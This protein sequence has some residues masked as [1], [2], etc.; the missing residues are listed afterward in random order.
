M[1]GTVGFTA[2]L[3]FRGVALFLPFIGKKA[4]FGGARLPLS[5]G[6]A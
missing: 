4:I 6:L 3:Q 5:S 2:F 1:V